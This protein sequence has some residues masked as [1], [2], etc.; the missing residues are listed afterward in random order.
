MAFLMNIR[1]KPRVEQLIK[2]VIADGITDEDLWRAFQNNEDAAFTM[3]YSRYAD[4]VYSYLKL[5]MVGTPRHIDDLF[6]DAWLQFFRSRNTFQAS[7][8]GAVAAWLFR[9]AHNMAVSQLRKKPAISIEDLHV[10]TDL[11]EGFTTPASQEQF[12]QPNS[13]AIMAQVM[14]SVE[15]LP[16]L[17]REVFILS[18]FNHLGLD[19][20]AET[21]GVSKQNVKVRLFRARRVIREDL[22]RDLDV[23]GIADAA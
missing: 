2:P 5:L 23:S 21:L 6:Q 18:E 22:A 11:I 3:I 9:L 4:R 8:P 17:L 1:L 15:H 7:A 14:K 19:Q 10:D 12:D 13:E 16:I 20:I